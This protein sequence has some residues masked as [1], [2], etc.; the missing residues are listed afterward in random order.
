MGMVLEILLTVAK[1]YPLWATVSKFSGTVLKNFWNLNLNVRARNGMGFWISNKNEKG[2]RN[3]AH[4]GQV[5]PPL[6]HCE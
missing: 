4:S 3:F 5:L 1:F 6:G 2:P